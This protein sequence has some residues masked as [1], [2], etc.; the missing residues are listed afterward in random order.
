MYL[1]SY[2]HL[3]FFLY[4]LQGTN[5][6]T[7]SPF[8][9]PSAQPGAPEEAQWLWG[10]LPKLP[11]GSCFGLRCAAGQGKARVPLFGVGVR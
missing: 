10:Y 3:S 4:L 8:G 9:T 1:R 5:E 11:S 2:Y 7:L 6:L